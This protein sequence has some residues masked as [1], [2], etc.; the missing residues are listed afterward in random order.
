MESQAT[1]YDDMS[2][3]NLIIE[4]KKIEEAQIQLLKKIIKN[5]KFV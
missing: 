2:D 3:K 4:I 1:H 5:K